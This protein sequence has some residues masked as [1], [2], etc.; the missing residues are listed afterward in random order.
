MDES[1]IASSKLNC[2]SSI[3]INKKTKQDKDT[4]YIFG[5]ELVLN[6]I[7]HYKSRCLLTKTTIMA[8]KKKS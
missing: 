2:L 5:T 4:K 8:K 6:A 1:S 7:G 3:A